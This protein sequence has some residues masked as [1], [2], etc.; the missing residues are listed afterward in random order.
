MRNKKGQFIKGNKEG[1]QEGH[2]R[3]NTGR[4]LF[5]KGHLP[6]NKGK[7][8]SGML[9]KKHSND[10]KMKMRG[11]K[12]SEEAKRK[13]SIASKGKP[14]SEIHKQKMREVLLGKYGENSKNWKGGL[15]PLWKLL[16]N[17]FQYRQWRCDVFERDSYTCQKCTL[18]G[19]YI[20]AHH[21]KPFIKILRENNI[22]TL[23]AA[24]QCVEL[25]NIN[26]GI[27]LCKKCHKEER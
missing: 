9:G 4:T 10:T 16:R 14:K 25:W 12:R 27:T 20:E 15:T 17:S 2:P 21:K 7:N 5:N 8:I 6:Y 22:K 23:D 18:K 3:Y 11:Q 19:C 26:N 13:M 24:F 1:F